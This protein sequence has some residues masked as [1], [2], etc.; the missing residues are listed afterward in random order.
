MCSNFVPNGMLCKAPE[1]PLSFAQH[2]PWKLLADVPPR[3]QDCTAMLAGVTERAEDDNL[4]ELSAEN[5]A[6]LC[7]HELRCS[8]REV[9]LNDDTGQDQENAEC[10]LKGEFRHCLPSS[11]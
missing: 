6:K 11:R 4:D 3:D 7:C 9:K 1:L 10:C 8:L 2:P 5:W